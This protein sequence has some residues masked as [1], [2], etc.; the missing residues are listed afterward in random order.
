MHPPKKLLLNPSYQSPRKLSHSP[1]QTIL[2]R[3]TTILTI[4]N[5]DWFFLFLISHE[6]SYTTCTLMSGFLYSLGIIRYHYVELFFFNTH[7]A[8]SCVYII[9]YLFFFIY[10]QM[11]S[12]LGGTIKNCYEYFCTCVCM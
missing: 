11:V 6:C 2:P 9:I 10:E 5:M 4:I 3:V 1:F 7:S 12:S 8:L